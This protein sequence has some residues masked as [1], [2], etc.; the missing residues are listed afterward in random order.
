MNDWFFKQG[1]RDRLIN[2][3]GIDSKINSVLTESWS[4]LKDS[5]NAG[6]SFFVRFQLT[7]WR[8]LLNEA[9]SEG[10]SIATGGFV[11]LY[12][13]ALPALLEFDESKF[14][15]GKFAVK[16][17]DVNGNELGK[18]GILHNDAVPLDEIPD[19]LIKATLATEDR[20]F[21]EHYGIDLWGTGRA[22][23]TNMQANEVVQ[24]GS[25]LTQQLAKNLF[26][27][28]ERS[29]QRKI[30][31]VFLSFLL[32]SRFTKREILKMYFDRAYMGGGAFGVEAAAQYYFGKSVREVTMAE[33]AMM[34]GLFKA[35]SKYAPHVNL[36]ASRARTNDVLDNL[37]EAGFYTS[38]QVHQARL[39]PAKT[40]D[41]TNTGSPDWFLDWAYEEVQ[42]LAEGK[43]QY[44]L[45]ARTTVDMSLQ[46]KAEEALNGS[47]AREGKSVHFNSGA[48]V[49]METDGSVKAI[50]G[51]QDYGENQFNRATKARR[52]PGSSFKVY[53][54]AA[55]MEAGMTPDTIMS[56]SSPAPCGPRGWTPQ[57]FGGG[58]GS[59]ERVPLWNALARSLNTVATALSFKVGR[60]KVIE[61]TKRLGINGVRKSCSMAL[62]DGGITVM[63]HTGGMAVFA[64]GGKLAK[65]YGILDITT[66]KGELL[67]SR[68]RDEPPAP[69]IIKPKIA[70][71]MNF[72]LQKVVTEG[73]GKASAL[74]FTNVAG[75]TGT[76]SGPTDLW[77][78]GFTGK[79]VAGVWL[80]N[81]DN[82]HMLGGSENTGGHIAA[83]IWHNF[84]A[85]AHSDM[86]IPAIPG[87]QIH[88]AQIAEMARVAEL[89][90][91]EAAAAASMSF[92]QQTPSEGAP[93]SSSILPDRTRESL[94][95]LAVALR[96]AGG[97]GEAPPPQSPA[98]TPNTKPAS[99]GASPSAA[100]P[101]A[102]ASPAPEQ[103]TDRR[104]TLQSG[105]GAAAALPPSPAAISPE[106]P[107]RGNQ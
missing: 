30:K 91:A 81:D 100:P 78:V 107:R 106:A 104:A 60:E 58:G 70:E 79:Y 50:V 63:E 71:E 68:E 36:P 53:V 49:V 8:R 19:P 80:G 57:N 77:F 101:A 11:V 69:Q 26:L 5:W 9:L 65:P 82:H 75:K 34:A 95:K 102:P 55:A 33:A 35:P 51:G 40:I 43:G 1:G 85:V 92:T 12:A 64:N 56:D 54:Y 38:G 94:K 98:G 47:V 76:S 28:S 25:T 62:G 72:M 31:E 89:K 2:W 83:P 73:T 22:L 61:L 3:L 48:M 32:E 93:K 39:S 27:S 90:K 96:K 37:V 52:Q 46:R 16:F 74:D 29:L 15:T 59:G 86:N 99:P 21:F 10:V 18:R 105:S 88:P 17:L 41:H 6:N 103:K 14:S 20:R 23:M 66:S 84:M 44:V 45:N 97:L 67:Y 42:R 13:L 87:L 24:G 7:G 4:K